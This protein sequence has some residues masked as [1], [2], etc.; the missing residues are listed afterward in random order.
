MSSYRVCHVRARMCPHTVG[1]IRL[2]GVP[3]L[4]TGAPCTGLYTPHALGRPTNNISLLFIK[5]TKPTTKHSPILAI[6]ILYS[7]GRWLCW[8]PELKDDWFRKSD[9]RINIFLKGCKRRI[10]GRVDFLHHQINTQ[11]KALL[12]F[13]EF[14]EAFQVRCL[15]YVLR[16]LAERLLSSFLIA[17]PPGSH[18]VSRLRIVRYVNCCARPKTCLKWTEMSVKRVSDPH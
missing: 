2:T 7:Y 6:G 11:Q 10:C 8:L 14:I 18:S 17:I 3:A 9:F 12:L 13:F 15:E 5:T 1:R 4:G 16:I